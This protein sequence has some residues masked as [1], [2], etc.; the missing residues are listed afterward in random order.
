MIIRKA[1][2]SDVIKIA[3]NNI[4]LAKESEDLDISLNAALSGVRSVL[5]DK[6]K[7]FYIVAE[8]NGNI[9]GEIMITY[10]WSDWRSKNMWWIQSA[11]VKK[12]FRKKGV[13][14]KLVKEIR[15][16]ADEK[17]I[18]IIRLYVHNKNKTAMSVY[19]KIGMEKNYS[20]YEFPLEI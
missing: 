4:L 7:G 5:C 2:L 9:I 13:F 8:D 14:K 11:Y 15:K 6:S 1:K 3:E 19:E 12:P 16:I 20:V 10:E 17:E 18:D